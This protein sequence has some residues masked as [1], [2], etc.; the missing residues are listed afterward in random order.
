MAASRRVP[1]TVAAGTL[2]AAALLSGLPPGPAPVA[3]EA[4]GPLSS[5]SRPWASTARTAVAMVSSTTLPERIGARRAVRQMITVSARSWSARYATLKAWQ[6]DSSGAWR[7]AH[8][9]VRVIVGYN[10]WV[11]A[12]DRRQ[13]TG[14]T[15]AGRFTVPYAFGRWADPGA[16]LR[17][18]QVDDRD[19]WPYEPRDPA[20]YNIW[21]Q[22]KAAGTTWRSDYAERL[23]S[24]GGQYG[25]ALVV[26]FNLPSGVHY[27]TSR[28]QWVAD[29]PADTRRGGGIFLHVQGDGP[30][31]GCV[32]MPR[33]E[34]RWL[35]RWLR[36]LLQPRLVMGPRDY[37]VR[38]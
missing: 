27:S 10:G 31:A 24:Y 22:H 8:G 11:A 16:R 5:T 15:P 6:R 19:W 13:S 14:T 29:D 23:A 32:A 33:A 28:R 36:P 34:M 30:T 21:Q 9:P 3:A 25:Y 20:T 35:V 7:L 26:G 37:I 38:L 4:S 17:Y 18:R 1:G 12:A 2:V